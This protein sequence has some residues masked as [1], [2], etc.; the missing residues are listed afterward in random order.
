MEIRPS[1]S[2]SVKSGKFAENTPLKS[3]GSSKN[4]EE[5]GECV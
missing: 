3:P 5:R 1:A 4:R 2:W